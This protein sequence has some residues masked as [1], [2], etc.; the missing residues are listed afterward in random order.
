MTKKIVALPVD[1]RP[2]VR[3]QVRALVQIGGCDFSAPA[4]AQLGHF[5][6]A[7]DCDSL[8][9]WLLKQ[10]ETADGFV[11]SLDMLVYGGLV[12][13]RFCAELL[14]QLLPRLD[15][16]VALKQ[17]YPEKPIY[18]FAAT[19]RMSNNNVAEEEK[20]YWAQYGTLIWTWS[21]YTD[22]FAQTNNHADKVLANAARAQ[23]PDDIADDYLE[24]RAR[25]VAVTSEALDL[26]EAGII[27]RLI[28]PQDDTA[29]YGFNIAERRDLQ[30]EI[31]VRNLGGDAIIYAGADE[32]MHTLCARM[33]ASFN[34]A[35]SMRIYV[36]LS[37]A[38]GAPTLRALYEDRPILDSVAAQ[39]AAVGAV[40]VDDAVQAD[41]I[42]LLHTQGAAQGDWAMRRALPSRASACIATAAWLTQLEGWYASGK[43]IAVADC[44]YANGGDPEMLALLN[45]KIGLHNLAAYAGWNTA[46]NTIGCVVAQCV[47]QNVINNRPKVPV[48][49]ASLGIIFNEHKKFLALRLLEDV[50]YQ[51]WLR[52]VIRAEIN[53][54]SLDATALE[55]VVADKFIAPANAWARA[56]QLGYEVANISLPW[57]RTFEIELHLTQVAS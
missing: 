11:L 1:G 43:L 26:L 38:A 33:V 32:V 37:D 16:L 21:F 36:H 47:L 22:K 42:L 35:P 30:L 29:E 9:Q 27:D 49:R 50:A 48:N 34:A 4:V 28:L 52:Q 56:H 44:A 10:A 15:V 19:M 40:R 53:E 31:N 25:N 2:A 41:V 24:T 7:A 8:S 55:N 46:S 54:P 12:P 5:R 6:Q 57:Q 20:T 45:V 39:I 18:A 23:I 13:S 14:E 17:N 3:E 51:A